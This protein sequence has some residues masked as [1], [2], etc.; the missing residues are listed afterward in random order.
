MN[1]HTIVK[2]LLALCFFLGLTHQAWAKDSYTALVKRIQPAVVTVATFDADK[3]P[4]GMGSGFFVNQEGHFITNRHVLEG[5]SQAVVKTAD[6]QVYSVADILAEDKAMDLILA[7]IGPTKGIVKSLRITGIMPEVG[8]RV[9]VIGSPLGLEQTISD[10][11][12]SAVR[13]IRGY[14]EILQI[15]APISKGSSGG[16]VVNL[17]GEVIGIATFQIV[18]GQ[19]L[20]FAIPG[21]RILALKPTIKRTL[22][23]W[24]TESGKKLD[25]Q[26]YQQVVDNLWKGRNKEADKIAQDVISN[27]P[28]NYEPYFALGLIYFT[29]ERPS[30]AIT[31]L[32]KAIQLGPLDK[33]R[34]M[35][36]STLGYSYLRLSSFEEAVVALEKSIK[37]NPYD[38]IPYGS[39]GR[40]YMG[41]AILINEKGNNQLACSYTKLSEEALKKAIN[42]KSDYNDARKTLEIVSKGR[43]LMRCR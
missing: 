28:K 17:K 36:F 22:T 40:A 19:N 25:K 7:S 35:I 12:V 1:N 41:L 30:D 37:I 4:R 21:F 8:E 31:F 6:G 43:Q 39:L 32:N 23:K 10:G 11:V 9:L 33:D 27:N 3:N 18:E 2:S 14:G 20:N 26:L 34:A 5:A 16:P 24:G 13:P 15:T 29:A 38:P 42:L